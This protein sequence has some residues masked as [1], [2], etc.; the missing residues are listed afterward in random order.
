[1]SVLC[2]SLSFLDFTFNSH[3]KKH[4]CCI[5]HSSM[6]I[7]MKTFKQTVKFH[8]QQCFLQLYHCSSTCSLL[9]WFLTALYYHMSVVTLELRNSLCSY[10]V[11]YLLTNQVMLMKIVCFLTSCWVI[12]SVNLL[13]VL[14]TDS[15]FSD[16]RIMNL[17]SFNNWAEDLKI[18]LTD[19]ICR[20]SQSR[21]NQINNSL[22]IK[23]AAESR[24]FLQY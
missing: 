4:M 22:K 9:S 15:D 6:L 12:K 11:K 8:M 21:P 18:L 10:V 13:S 17:I 7:H 3:N 2:L 5:D 1:M 23:A 14:H 19:N 20:D 16:L 24:L